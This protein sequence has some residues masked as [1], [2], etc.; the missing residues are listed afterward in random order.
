MRDMI[1][2]GFRTNGS[3]KHEEEEPCL[4]CDGHLHQISLKT[5]CYCHHK[6][7][8]LSPNLGPQCQGRRAIPDTCSVHL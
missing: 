2:S 5:K 4:M 3:I 6:Q 1:G 8:T 7:Q